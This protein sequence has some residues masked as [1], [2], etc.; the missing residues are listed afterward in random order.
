MPTMEP[1]RP[2]VTTLAGLTVFAILC[3][4][5]FL[6]ALGYATY[7]YFS[8]D[9]PAPPTSKPGALPTSKP[10]APPT[11]P[12]VA[13]VL[14]QIGAPPTGPDVA[15]VLAQI[16]APSVQEMRTMTQST[17][18]ALVERLRGALALLPQSAVTAQASS[19]I[20]FYRPKDGP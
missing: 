19:Y 9:A 6:C 5:A 13:S 8:A 14:A 20:D 18:A 11:G 7:T 15:S 16:G 17:L 2:N 10:G 12:D 1:P 3:G 4:V